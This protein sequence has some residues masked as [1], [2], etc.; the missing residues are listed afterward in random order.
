MSGL[1]LALNSAINRS[2]SNV[3]GLKQSN[4]TVRN[5]NLGLGLAPGAESFSAALF[6][7]FVNNNNRRITYT[8]ERLYALRR[9]TNDKKPKCRVLDSI[10]DAGVVHWRGSRGG[11]QHQRSIAVVKGY[12]RYVR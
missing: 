5:A 6:N 4:N 3:I 7:R 9:E 11:R 1:R 2:V 8:K 10:V 12:G